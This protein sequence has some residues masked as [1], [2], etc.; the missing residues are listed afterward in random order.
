V[1]EDPPGL[2][3]GPLTGV[4]A[5]LRWAAGRGADRL[6]TA[7]CDTPFL[8]AD[9]VER[10]EAALGE[11]DGAAVAQAPDG[12]HP[13]CGLWRVRLA[14]PLAAELAR[15]HPPVRAILKDLGGR[16][17]DFPDA[18][19]FANINTPGDLRQAEAGAPRP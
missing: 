3:K 7:P 10:L 12:P 16:L 4:L 1:L 19:A 15:G 14:A 17:V 13:L 11:A 5:G 2:A 6:A 18:A 8:P 9:L